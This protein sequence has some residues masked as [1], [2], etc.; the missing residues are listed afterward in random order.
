MTFEAEAL[1]SLDLKKNDV[2]YILIPQNDLTAKK[3][4]IGKTNG[5]TPYKENKPGGGDNINLEYATVED[6][7]GLF[8]DNS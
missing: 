6:I 4:I 7:N 8:T 1:S 5:N 3:Y 2:V